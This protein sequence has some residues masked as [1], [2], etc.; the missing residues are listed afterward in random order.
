MCLICRI[1]PCVVIFGGLVVVETPFSVELAPLSVPAWAGGAASS[2]RAPAAAR[3]F[4]VFIMCF[5]LGET[6]CI[7]AARSVVA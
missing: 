2:A 3:M 6:A 7:R 1:W 5:F 4:R